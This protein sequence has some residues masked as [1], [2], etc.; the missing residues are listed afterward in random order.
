MALALAAL[1]SALV[2]ERLAI[3]ALR[4]CVVGLGLAVAGRF[5]YEPRIVGDAL[6]KTILFNWLLFGY[7]VPALAFG[8]AAR[9]MRRSGEDAPMCVAQALSILCSAL[10]LA[11]EIRHALNDGDPFAP[12]SGLIEQGLFAT[13][14]ILFSLVLMELNARRADPLYFFASLGFGALTLAQ[15]IAGLLLWEN[16]YFSGVGIEGGAWF[17]GLIPGYCLPAL[18]ALILARRARGRP[19]EWRRIAA[20]A[21]AIALLF[22][23]VNLELRRLFQ[24][25]P[26]IS[27]DSPTGDGELYAYSALWLALGILLLAYGIATRSKPARLASAAL[28]SLTVVKVFLLDLAGLEGVLR[29]LS[30]LG[31]GATLIGIGLVYQKFV[32]AR[33][34]DAADP[35]AKTAAPPAEI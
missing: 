8:L 35:D 26:A 33:R 29:A 14:G 12:T 5:L 7:G 3:P 22:A 6:G 2:S 31:L 27:Y 25:A 24:G 21:A 1:G 4:W 13:V 10:L 17:N 34:P 19:P 11:F 28:V 23:Y 18:A 16:P 15:T 9:L 30:F 20:S 32:F